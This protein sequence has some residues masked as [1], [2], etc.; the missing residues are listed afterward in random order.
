MTFTPQSGDEAV[1]TLRSLVGPVRSEPGCSAT[2]VQRGAEQSFELTWFSEWC[3]IE[4]FERHLREPT[5]RQI[6]AVI[7]M[8]KGPPDVEIDDVN[9][10]RGF[11]LI[12]EILGRAQAERAGLGSG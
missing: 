8:A 5:F 2:R 9:S 12:E 6:L 7:E 10:R 11:E 4:D 3:G 1:A